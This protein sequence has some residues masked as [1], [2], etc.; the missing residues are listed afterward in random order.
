MLNHNFAI[1]LSEIEYQNPSVFFYRKYH[2]RRSFFFQ[3]LR[4]ECYELVES[5]IRRGES[6]LKTSI[7]E[8]RFQRLY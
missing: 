6:Y 1:F 5:I 2:L 8:V 7:A 4:E 3:K